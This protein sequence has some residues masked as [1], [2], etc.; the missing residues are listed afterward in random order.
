MDNDSFAPEDPGP[1]FAA[2]GCDSGWMIWRA[3]RVSALTS[4]VFFQRG[5]L[6]AKPS[7]IHRVLQTEH[8]KSENLISLI[9][10]G[11]SRQILHSLSPL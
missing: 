5:T 10:S 9:G 8:F 3:A 1:C 7:H 6:R 11:I 4:L 2:L